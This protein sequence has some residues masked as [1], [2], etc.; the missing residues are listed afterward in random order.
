MKKILVAGGTGFIGYHVCK[1]ALKK[2]FITVSISKNKPSKKRRLKNVKY[3]IQDLKNKKKLEK[4]NWN[5]DVVIN[6]SGYGRLLSTKAKGILFYRNHT[7]SLKNLVE[8]SHNKYL[9]KFIHLGSSTEYGLTKPPQK[10]NFICKPINI[11]GKA[12]LA[13]TNY[14]LNCFKKD[15]LPCVILRLFQV[16][17]PLQQASKIIPFVI[18]NSKKNK[19][20]KVTNG[21]QSRDF[22]FIDD[23]VKAI[24]KSID[25][26]RANGQIINIGYGKSIKLF[27]VIEYII[28]KIGQ[29]KALYGKKLTFFK[30]NLNLYPN[31]SKAKKFLNWSPSVNIYSGINKLLN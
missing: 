17:G 29:G 6:C 14:L 27:H 19:K 26:N 7:I 22:L 13:C 3:I 20:F 25:N 16:Y 30:E 2:K 15:N 31:I 5:Y 12:K 11:Y 23:V 21:K 24:F 4:L 1:F 8:F 9:K 10:E 18:S 28:K